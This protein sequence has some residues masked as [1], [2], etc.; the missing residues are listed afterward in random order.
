MDPQLIIQDKLT[1][2]TIFS[3]LN[4]AIDKFCKTRYSGINAKQEGFEQSQ[5]RI[6]DLRMLVKSVTYTESNS[7]NLLKIIDLGKGKYSVVL[8]IDYMVLLGDTAGIVPNTTDNQCWEKQNGEYI[9]KY[10]D[11]IEASIETLDKQL[12]NS[13]SEHKLKYNQAKPLRLI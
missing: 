10:G 6:D 3:F 1:S 11:T 7:E 5:K 2:D 8:P 13:L 4:E 12:S 9:V